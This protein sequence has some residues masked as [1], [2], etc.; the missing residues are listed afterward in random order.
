MGNQIQAKVGIPNQDKNRRGPSRQL[1]LDIVTEWIKAQH[2]DDYTT[3]GLV[4]LAQGYPTNAL[5]SFRRNFQVMLARVRQKR[6]EEQ[7]GTQE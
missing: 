3:K 6:R 4:E 1:T 7:N 5:P 2:L